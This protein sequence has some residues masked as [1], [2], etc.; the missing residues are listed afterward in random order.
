M[1]Q[2]LQDL[3]DKN[4]QLVL[5]PAS[6]VSALLESGPDMIVSADG[7]YIE[8]AHGNRLLDAVGGLWC[9][10]VG[11]G[12]RELA[13][14]MQ[15]TAEKLAYYHTFSNASNPWQVQ[16]AERLLEHAPAGL[17]KVFYG[18][19][20]SDAND[21]LIKIA[22]HYHT[23]CGNSGKTKVI[24]REQGYHGTSISTASLTGL[25]G[26]HKGFPL[27]QDFV[28][29]VE[30]P[31]YYTRGRV[32]ETEEAFCT[33]L[34]DEVATLIAN[35]GA[36]TIAAFFAEPIMGAG[37][38]I[39]PPEGYYLRLN[40]LLK[41]HDIFLVAD[42]VVC[43]YGRLGTW[44][45]SEQLGLEPDMISTAKGLTSGYFPM[46]AAMIS[47]T[48]WDVLKQGSEQLGAFSHGYTYGGHPV[49]CAVALVNLDIIEREELVQRAAESGEYLHAQLRRHLAGHPNVGEIR[50]RGLIA[51][52]QLVEDKAQRQV[53]DP[54]AKWPLRVAKVTRQHGVV[55]R[56]LLG[57]GTLA[58]SPPLTISKPQIDVL[59]AALGRGIDSLA[60]G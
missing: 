53:P 29:R 9:V 43:G 42:E 11:Y 26:F 27:P 20:G 28:L 56:P 23:L 1:Q 8:D 4:A 15:Q 6:S 51:G 10:N 40:K 30:C 60:S 13:R 17:G 2:D 36:D 45:G 44:F 52:V 34:I 41:K 50:G 54:A 31:H 58:M 33:R 7:C 38:V 22:W 18:S 48:I 39:E 35:E 21:T 14:A 25:G 19:G 12:R 32:D 5:H 3:I 46:S 57:V 16:L 59:V 55:V 24:A 49:G 37:G 47:D